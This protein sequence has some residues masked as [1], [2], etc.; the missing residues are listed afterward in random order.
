MAMP[1]V[2]RYVADPCAMC[3]G[4]GSKILTVGQSLWQ[5]KC[6]VG[7]HRTRFYLHQEDAVQA[8]NVNQRHKVNQGKAHG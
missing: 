2:D 5:V 8:W 3:A 6:T 4:A 1:M 7:R